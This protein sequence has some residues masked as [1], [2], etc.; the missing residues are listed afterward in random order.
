MS[1]AHFKRIRH[2]LLII[3]SFF[4]IRQEENLGYNPS[5]PAYQCPPCLH[6]SPSCDQHH[7]KDHHPSSLNPIDSEAQRLILLKLPTQ[8]VL[9]NQY[10]TTSYCFG[11]PCVSSHPGKSLLL[12]NSALVTASLYKN[13]FTVHFSQSNLGLLGLLI[14]LSLSISMSVLQYSK[15]WCT[16]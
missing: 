6:A 13:L 9:E 7:I 4:V 16:R 15:Q 1:Q 8:G 12:P 14:L 3:I 11:M 10:I 5:H 2:I